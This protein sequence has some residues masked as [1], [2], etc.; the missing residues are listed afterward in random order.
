[1]KKLSWKLI[2]L[3][4]VLS[5]VLCG[6][7]E[8][9]PAGDGTTATEP[10][11]TTEEALKTALE[12]SGRV[13]L[14]ADITLTSQVVVSGNVFDGGGHTLT[15]PAYAEGDAATENGITVTGGTVENVT[16]KGAYRGIGDHKGS[17]SIMDVRLNNVTVDSDVYTLN[18]GYGNGS[19]GLYVNG[20]TLQGWTSYTKFK[21]AQ[22]TDCTFAWCES[23][24]NGN[25]RPYINTTL[26]GCR[27]EGKTEA[28]GTVTPFNIS[29]K[30]GTDGIL[31]VL[32]DC[33]VGDT[34]ITQENLE[35]LL[36]VDVYG[37]TIQVRNTVS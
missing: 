28:D 25:L 18:F 13:V 12:T 19:A 14:G 1:M 22:F 4:L 9:K 35:Q 21:E 27:F 37:N 17:G 36:N 3:T 24:K 30:S 20:S 26:I 16:V 32:E 34:L 8:A 7:G 5:F 33:Y 6:C 23:G 10:A 29:F 11:I 2:C 15:G 31:L